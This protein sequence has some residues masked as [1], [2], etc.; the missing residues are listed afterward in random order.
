VRGPLE[1][2]KEPWISN[3]EM[4]QVPLGQGTSP[5]WT[6]L[7]PIKPIAKNPNK[8]KYPRAEI[9]YLH[10]KL[11][12]LAWESESEQLKNGARLGFGPFSVSYPSRC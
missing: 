8:Q 10:G 1:R 3:G 7:P 6:C 4:V 12:G 5:L 9:N 11:L 2:V